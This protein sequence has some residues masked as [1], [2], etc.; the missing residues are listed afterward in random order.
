MSIATTRTSGGIGLVLTAPYAY[1]ETDRARFQGELYTAP[2]GQTSTHDLQLAADV[3]LQGGWY[4]VTDPAPGDRLTF[5][6]VDVDNITGAGA[7][8]IVSEYVSGLPVA[9]WDHQRDLEAHTAALIPAG[10]YLRVTYES[11]GGADVRLGVCYRWYLQ[12]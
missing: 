12:E 7:G 11:T 5:Q 8:A 3:R 4:W 9:P 1:S 2:A 10:L 6:V